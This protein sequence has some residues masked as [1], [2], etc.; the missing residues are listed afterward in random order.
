M[1]RVWERARR[2]LFP[3]WRW[4]LPLAAVSAA[5][6]YLV[7][8]RGLES[9]PLAYAVYLLSAYGLTAAAGLAVRAG[10]RVWQW[11][12]SIPLA[13][14]WL[15]DEYFRVW[16]GL[17]LSFLVNLCYAGLKVV[18]AVLYS[19]FWEGALGFYYILLSAV[20]LY[21]L[22]HTPSSR[23]GTDYTR[24][25]RACRWVGVHLLVLNLALL[26]ISVQIVRD[27][28]GYHYPGTLIYAAA[29]YSFYC[30]TLAVIHAVKYRAL[31]SPALTAAKAVALTCAL[32]SIFSLETAML[33][34]F[35]G[36]PQFQFIMTASTAAWVCVLVLV[37][38]LF[39]TISASRKLRRQ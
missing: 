18:C 9:A 1:K 29:A 16:A 24:E 37:T 5:G 32:V 13:V 36:E 25:L 35:G 6:L 30:L 33:S 2:Y 28:Q 17:L 22:R 31:R 21:L 4:T 11:V 3:C 7:F 38:T 23:G 39:M 19:S 10:R 26:W 12:R 8:T 15:E 27:G 34:Q 20:R 14:R